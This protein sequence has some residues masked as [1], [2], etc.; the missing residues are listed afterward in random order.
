MS[1]TTL[2][3]AICAAA[4]LLPVAGC[5]TTAPPVTPKPSPTVPLAPE[6]TPVLPS[7]PEPW[8]DPLEPVTP[9]QDQPA[10]DPRF[11]TCAAA[12]RAGYG[13]YRRGDPEFGWYRDSDRDGVVCER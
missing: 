13:P 2:G 3:A 11:A 4:L 10:T 12:V 5:G 6:P 1:R 9:D 7:Q 8:S